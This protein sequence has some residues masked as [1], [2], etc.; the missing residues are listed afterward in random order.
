MTYQKQRRLFEST[1]SLNGSQ[2]G[3][4]EKK[5]ADRLM[6]QD[7]HSSSGIGF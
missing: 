3:I 7:R 4:P 6:I 2:L 1:N 5:A